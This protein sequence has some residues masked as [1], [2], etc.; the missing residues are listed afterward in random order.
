MVDLR[1]GLVGMIGLV[2]VACGDSEKGTATPRGQAGASGASGAAGTGGSAAGRAGAP[3]SGGTSGGSGGV[4]TG[5]AGG[6]ASAGRGGDGGVGGSGGNAGGSSGAGTAGGAGEGGEGAEPAGG[7]SGGAGEGG[8]GGVSETVAGIYTFDE[9]TSSPTCDS[10]S[11]STRPGYPATHLVVQ[12]TVIPGDVGG[13]RPAVVVTGCSGVPACRALA[14]AIADDFTTYEA[15][16]YYL[17]Q[18]VDP[19][20]TLTNTVVYYG[21]LDGAICRNGGIDRVSLS[22]A[23][24]QLTLE[25]RTHRTDYPAANDTCPANLASQ[26]GASAACTLLRVLTGTRVELL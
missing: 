22:L 12:N 17:F 11:T 5:G 9:A 4:T 3:G 18:S 25:V 13:D 7:A 15:L 16:P 14:A 10:V 2:L 24:A 21:T 26:A 19:D 6:G 8:A 20:G 23:G 1:S